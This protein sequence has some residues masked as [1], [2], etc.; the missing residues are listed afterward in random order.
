MCSTLA[1]R[2]TGN[3][4]NHNNIRMDTRVMKIHAVKKYEYHIR[5]IIFEERAILDIYHSVWA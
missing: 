3:N 4:S 2:Q 5:D 1:M